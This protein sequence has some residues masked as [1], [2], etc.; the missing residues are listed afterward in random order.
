MPSQ[1]SKLTDREGYAQQFL[2]HLSGK[3]YR[4]IALK[5]PSLQSIWDELEDPDITPVCDVDLQELNYFDTAD[6]LAQRRDTLNKELQSILNILN[7]QPPCLNK[8]NVGNYVPTLQQ[9]AL[10]MAVED[11]KYLQQWITDNLQE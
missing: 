10:K 4:N 7:G 5:N 11:K 8:I 3:I 6:W 2:Q 1:L 9:V